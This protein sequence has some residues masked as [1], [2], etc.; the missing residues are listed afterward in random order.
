MEN[1]WGRYPVIFRISD[2]CS[3]GMPH[4]FTFPLSFSSRVESTFINVVLPAPFLPR[5]PNIP[6]PI[7]RSTFFSACFF[8][9]DLL[10]FLITISVFIAVILS[11]G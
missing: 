6:F 9:Y 8:P 1:S 3:T 10:R 7:R 2:A 5:S 11:A 4:T